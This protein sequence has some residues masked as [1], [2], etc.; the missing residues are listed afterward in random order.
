MIR[1]NLEA[2]LEAKKQA[3]EDVKANIAV[4]RGLI[5]RLENRLINLNTAY[6][7]LTFKIEELEEQIEEAK[8][9]YED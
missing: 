3:L 8:A 9:D 6:T 7:D 1:P 4:V 2:E 5:S